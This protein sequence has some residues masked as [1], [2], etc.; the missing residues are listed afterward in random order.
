MIADDLSVP[1][2]KVFNIVTENLE[3]NVQD[4]QEKDLSWSSSLLK[5]K[6][7][8]AWVQVEIRGIVVLTKNATH[9]SKQMY[10]PDQRQ[11]KSSIQLGEE[12]EVIFAYN[13]DETKRLFF[14]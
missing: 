14:D 4:Q 9:I 10:C 3:L 7:L 8:Q 11:F 12:A 6:F 13:F 5:N 1:Q 2:T